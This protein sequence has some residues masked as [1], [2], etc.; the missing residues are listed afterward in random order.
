MDFSLTDDQRSLRDQIIRFGQNELSPGARQR[1]AAQQFPHDLWLK[2]G[3]MGLQGLPIPTEYGGTG[4]D[5]LSTVI[6]IEALGY[7]CEDTGLVFA[8]CAHMLACAVPIWLHGSEEQKQKYLPDMC[9]GQKIAVNAM[10]EPEGGS[11]AFNMHTRAVE[12]DHGHL[13]NGTKIFASNAPVADIAILYASTNPDRAF[14]GGIT[15]F[16]VEATTPGYI[17]GQKFEKMGLRTCPIGELVFDDLQVGPDNVL[18]KVGN[19][20][21]VFSQSMEWERICLVAAHVGKMEWLLERAID[22]AKNRSAFGQKIG[23]FQGVSH[24]IADMKVRLEAARLLTYRAASMLGTRN[25]VALDAAI[26]KLF[27]SEELIK[28]ALDAI[29]VMGGYGFMAE[30]DV[31][32]SLRDSVAGTIYSGTS[33]MQRNIIANWLGL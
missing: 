2:C 20:G 24:K 8:I 28:S 1:D 22:Y 4:L 33:E 15:A 26:T 14:I 17:R 13:I 3:E 29:Q 31:E 30:Y 23:G 27:V 21:P 25:S 7:S 12:N 11:D 10:T 19:G 32:R 5:P 16:V 18:A 6:A 9:S